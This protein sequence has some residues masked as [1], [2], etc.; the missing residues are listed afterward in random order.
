MSSDNTK[1]SIFNDKTAMLELWK[2]R[3]DARDKIT[4]TM[5]M[6]A[7]RFFALMSAFVSA[8]LIA[9]GTLFS[10]EEQSFRQIITIALLVISVLII[11]IS[12][13]GRSG[14]QRRYDSYLRITA[15]IMKLEG[16]MGLNKNLQPKLEELGLFK[17]D[18]SL[19]DRPTFSKKQYQTTDSFV[20]GERETGKTGK[21]GDLWKG[22]SVFILIGAVLTIINLALCIQQLYIIATLL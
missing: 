18:T 19:F 6:G 9:F 17:D 21:F 3:Y 15:S 4:D 13:V 14:L 20:E 7:E 2:S 10:F 16:L 1:E 5:W 8:N 12:L 22:Y 11:G